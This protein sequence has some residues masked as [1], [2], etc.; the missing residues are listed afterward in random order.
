MEWDLDVD[1]PNGNENGV[2]DE[3]ER[4]NRLEYLASVGDVIY[5]EDA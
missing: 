5:Y 2:I 1:P 4:T 3:F